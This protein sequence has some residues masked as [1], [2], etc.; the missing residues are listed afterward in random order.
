MSTILKALRRLEE[1]TSTSETNT[2]GALPATDPGAA[3]ELRG[4]LLAEESVARAAAA[5][6]GD[7]DQRRRTIR[8]ATV[9]VL[10][11][12]LGIGTYSLTA[13][14]GSDRFG[15]VAP[16]TPS[17]PAIATTVPTVPT[18]SAAPPVAAAAT[19]PAAVPDASAA[20]A[21]AVP[22]VPSVAAVLAVAPKITPPS[23]ESEALVEDEPA[24]TAVNEIPSESVSVQ[25]L[26]GT[27]AP[28]RSAPA[29]TIAVGS[30][31]VRDGSTSASPSG[32]RDPTRDQPDISEDP[33]TVAARQ[34]QPQ[35]QFQPDPISGTPEPEPSLSPIE[36]KEVKRHERLELPDLTIIRT[37]W[38]PIAER[39]T[40]K[41]R[42]EKSNELLTLREGDAVGGLVV[43]KISP[44][45]VLFDAGDV[46]IRHRIGPQR[47]VD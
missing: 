29:P 16:A 4:R 46:E 1:D 14:N 40:V 36:P 27:P 17:T 7:P 26:S 47:S 5:A 21:Y 12:G 20:T 45:S 38:H 33:P 19:T 31:S 42:L 43:K 2:D 30:D 23:L 44:S 13:G 3:D 18:V 41:I 39:R 10:I 25:S 34:L 15:S 6:H 37:A 11:F 22:A 35:L 24:G 32:P 9:A 8:L 28:T